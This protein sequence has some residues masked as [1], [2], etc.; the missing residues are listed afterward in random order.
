MG[1][2]G[3]WV[4]DIYV[5][6]LYM[7]YVCLI[8][9]ITP[10]PTD[11]PFYSTHT[12]IHTYAHIRTYTFFYFSSKTDEYGKANVGVGPMKRVLVKDQKAA[13]LPQRFI[14]RRSRTAFSAPKDFDSSRHGDAEKSSKPPAFDLETRHVH[15][16]S[17][18]L[19]VCVYI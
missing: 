16:L 5:Y 15:G 18:Q 14:S 8:Y 19:Y 10:R 7:Y 4:T 9:V 12:Y 6:V 1:P 3:E 11:I 2:L 13:A 17:S